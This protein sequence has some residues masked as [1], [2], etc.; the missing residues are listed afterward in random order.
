[1]KLLSR[2]VT[3][4]EFDYFIALASGI[5]CIAIGFTFDG[6]MRVI[7]VLVAVANFGR[8][9]NLTRQMRK[10]REQINSPSAHQ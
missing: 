4:P 5:C 7:A 2:Q 1:M 9:L 6:S 8:L 10:D 3:T